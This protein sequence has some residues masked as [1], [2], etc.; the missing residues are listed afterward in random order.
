M[1]ELFRLAVKGA[2]LIIRGLLLI[3]FLLLFLYSVKVVAGI[4]LFDDLHVEDFIGLF[5]SFFE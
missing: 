4:D 5:L 2:R 1:T 3:V